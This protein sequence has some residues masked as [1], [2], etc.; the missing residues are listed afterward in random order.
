MTQSVMCVDCKALVDLDSDEEAC[1]C[2]D[3]EPRCPSCRESFDQFCAQE[4]CYE[5]GLN[6]SSFLGV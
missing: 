4:D 6:P 3:G 2:L 1:N 5:L